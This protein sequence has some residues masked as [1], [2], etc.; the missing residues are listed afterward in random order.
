ML[1][2]IPHFPAQHVLIA[3]PPPVDEALRPRRANSDIVAYAIVC[4]DVAAETVCCSWG[5]QSL[6]E[7]ALGEQT[8]EVTVAGC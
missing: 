1:M 8:L 5:K 4:R 2:V 7:H 3:A 6:G